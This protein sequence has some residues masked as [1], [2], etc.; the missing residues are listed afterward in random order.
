QLLEQRTQ[1]DEKI[2]QLERRIADAEK[3]SKDVPAPTT[4][5][6]VV[7]R[8]ETVWKKPPSQLSPRPVSPPQPQINPS[9]DPQPNVIPPQPHQID[10]SNTISGPGTQT[11]RPQ[12]PQ[13]RSRP[14]L[15]PVSSY[16]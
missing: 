13:G 12:P 4:M 8:E 2:A 7:V 5:G 1:L 3:K 9:N 6:E 10:K 14:P 11:Y 16:T 15:R